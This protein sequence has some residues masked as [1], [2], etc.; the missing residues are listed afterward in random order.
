MTPNGSAVQ[1]T[2]ARNIAITTL[3]VFALLLI[4]AVVLIVTNNKD[5][6]NMVLGVALGTVTGSVTTTAVVARSNGFPDAAPAD[7]TPK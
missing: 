2:P 3:A 5:T 7:A 6:G 1:S 4:A